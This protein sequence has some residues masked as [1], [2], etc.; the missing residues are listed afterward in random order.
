MGDELMTAAVELTGITKRFGDVT[1]VDHVDLA[2]ED[3][4]FFAMLGPSGCGKTTTLRMIA[5]LEFPTEGSLKIFGDEVGTLPPNKR[6]VNTVFQNYA[7]FPHMNVLD[8]VAFGLRMRKVSKSEARARAAEAI[9][10]VQLAGLE[11]RKPSQ[12]SGGQQQR[13]AIARALMH[14]PKLVFADEPTSALDDAN[15][16]EVMNLLREQTADAG[17]TLVVV[18][19]DQRLKDRIANTIAL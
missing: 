11:N 16:A 4:E 1:A 7:L 14:R 3:G 18:T 5:G 2:I 12:M 19:H 6:P 10:L 15:A 9:G 8:N 17:A 13:V